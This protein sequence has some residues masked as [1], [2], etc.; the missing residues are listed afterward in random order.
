[1]SVISSLEYYQAGARPPE[2]GRDDDAV[3]PVRQPAV[4]EFLAH[5]RTFRAVFPNVIVAF[6]P[7]GYG[8]YMLGSDQPIAFD[9]REHPRGPRP[10]GRPRGHVV[11]VRLAGARCRRL[12]GRIPSLVWISG[13]EVARI[14]GD[15]PLITD[16]RPL[17]EYFLLRTDI[18]AAVAAHRRPRASELSARPVD[19]TSMEDRRGAHRRTLADARP[20]GVQRGGTARPGAG[21]ALR[22][23]P[24]P[25]GPAREGAPGSGNL[26]GPIRVLVVDDGSTDG[27]RRDRRGAGPRSRGRSGRARRGACELLT[28]PARRQGRRG[29]GRDARRRQPT[30]SSSPTPTWRRRPTSCPLLV[31]ALGR[32]RRGARAAGSSR[33]ARTCARRQPGYRRLLGKVFH[34]LASVWVVG[35]VAGHPVRVQGLHARRRARPVRRQQRITSIVFDVELIYLARRRGYRIAVVPIRW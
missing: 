9:R 34:A 35:P 8:L 14:A 30:W 15:G 20:A 32:P 10:A 23:P 12:G 1:M 2:P 28:R 29:P 31:A 16:D 11:G 13:D 24:P 21:R 26:P 17:P 25:G 3:G 33:T 27:D 4:D 7:G 6:G 5:I 19:C 22:L 18:R